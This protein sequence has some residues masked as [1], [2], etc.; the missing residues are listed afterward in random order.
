MPYFE[1]A[2]RNVTDPRAS[3]QKDLARLCAVNETTQ[4]PKIHDQALLLEFSRVTPGAAP[5]GWLW[6]L[7]GSLPWFEQD[8]ATF[9]L[10]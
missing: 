9:L 2:G 10:V 7:N 3:C 4:R 1:G 8:L 6:L 5:V